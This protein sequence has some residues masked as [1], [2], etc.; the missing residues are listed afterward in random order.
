MGAPLCLLR[1][2]E[3][4]RAWVGEQRYAAIGRCLRGKGSTVG[5][6]ACEGALR[7]GGAFGE[8][9]ATVGENACEGV[10][11]WGGAFGERESTIGES[12]CEDALRWGGVFGERD[13]Q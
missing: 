3:C 2:K 12:A 6:N 4:E 8:R 10:L 11:R 13:Q 7:W 9:G 1:R 5:E